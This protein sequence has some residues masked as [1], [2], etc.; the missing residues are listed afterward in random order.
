MNHTPDLVVFVEPR[1]SGCKADSVIA[2]LGFPYSHRVEAIGFSGGIW[3]AWYDSVSVEVIVNHF[4]FIHC[5]VTAKLSGQSVYAT[6]IY[7]SPSPACRKLLW[8]HLRRLADTIHSPCVLF[9]DFNATLHA[10]DRIGCIQTPA[11]LDRFLCNS[12]WDDTFPI[13]VVSHLLRLCSDHRPILLQVGNSSLQHQK[14]RF[15]YFSEWLSHEDFHPDNLMQS[16]DDVPSDQ[17]IYNA[18]SDMAPLKSP[19]W[20]GLHA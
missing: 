15:R 13:S 11:R 10:N 20:D 14:T 18:L 2:A 16:L 1:I 12:Y 7:A 3:L 17:E 19:G 9:G 5:R 8:P 4:Q 6:A